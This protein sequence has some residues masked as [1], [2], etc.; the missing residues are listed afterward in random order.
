MASYIG[1]HIYIPPTFRL[2][3][4]STTT[5]T[6]TTTPVATTFHSIRLG[7]SRNADI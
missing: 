1:I 5:T 2:A 7:L 4:P 3:Q 6:S